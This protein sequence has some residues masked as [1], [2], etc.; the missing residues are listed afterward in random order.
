M[1]EITERK[2]TLIVHSDIKVKNGWKNTEHRTLK[3]DLVRRQR[4]IMLELFME[5]CLVIP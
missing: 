1:L 4:T 5:R 2:N 3:S